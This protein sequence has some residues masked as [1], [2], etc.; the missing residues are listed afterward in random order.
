M[1]K[2]GR[3]MVGTDSRSKGVAE[4]THTVVVFRWDAG[5][6]TAVFPTEPGD[7]TGYD[8]VCYA[9][10]GQ[11]GSCAKEWYFCTRPAKPEEYA[12]LKAELELAPYNYV[13]TVRRKITRAMDDMRL[14][15]RRGRE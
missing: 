14:D 9:H 3:D 1:G 12:E 10:I 5:E 15:K 7:F 11:H 13:L 6:V 2:S 8:M 4:M